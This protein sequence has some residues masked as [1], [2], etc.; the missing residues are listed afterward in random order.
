MTVR[1]ATVHDLEPLTVDDA[2]TLIGAAALTPSPLGRVGLELESHLV[3]LTTPVERVEWDRI[4]DLTPELT[5]AAGR[6][7]VTFEPGGQL[8]LSG[9]PRGGI[10][11]A[12]QQMRRDVQR[13]RL[14][15]AE[16]GTGLAL[17]GGDP[18]RAPARVNPRSRYAAMERHFASLGRGA[19][20]ATMMCSTSALQVNLDAGP[21]SGWA[22]RV[23]LAQRL[24]PTLSALSACS[25]WLA[26]RAAGHASSRAQA[27]SQLG[28]RPHICTDP[29]Q[30]WTRY[31]LAA[32][33]MFAGQ[34]DGQALAVTAHVPFADWLSGRVQLAGRRPTSTDLRTHLSTLFPPVRLRGYLELRYLDI[35][36]PR[37]WPAV[38]AVTTV[39]LEDPVAAD[40]AREAVEPVAQLWAEAAHDG[41]RDPRLAAAADRCLEIA[42]AHVPAALSTA[43]D[44]LAELVATG[45][46]PGDLLADRIA[47][48][49]PLAAF[50]EAAHA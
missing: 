32:P 11:D 18:L 36:P 27:W 37:W 50:V 14:T 12:V 7:S 46:T 35:S 39:L 47:E 9:P 5:T 45:R 25:P 6:S 8:E 28:E 42:A 29:V 30:E 41:L 15:L 34:G 17:L 22:D 48:I 10:L 40:R 13:V 4:L 16:H 49:G 2:E 20:G 21:E 38:A 24:G 3:D 43:V 31:A 33:V 19:A 44:D 26:G 23:A 1:S